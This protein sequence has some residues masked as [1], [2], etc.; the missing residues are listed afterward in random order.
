ELIP[1]PM[2]CSAV[3]LTAMI[4]VRDRATADERGVKWLI[5]GRVPGMVLGALVVTWLSTTGLAIVFAFAILA[6][7]AVSVAGV[8]LPQTTP[9]LLGAGTMS[10]LMGTTL[11]VGGPPLALAYQRSHGSEIRGTLEAYETVIQV[12]SGN[13]A[14]GDLTDWIRRSSSS[15]ATKQ[16]S[17]EASP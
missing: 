10:G 7:V 9:A 13:L 17:P 6:I 8:S 14:V 16:P 12:A 15:T 4:T 3:L 2:L 5:V 11:G 1:G